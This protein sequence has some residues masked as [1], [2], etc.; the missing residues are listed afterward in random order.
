MALAQKKTYI[1]PE[2]YLEIR[3]TSDALSEYVDGEVLAMAGNSK[4][5]G[6]IVASLTRLVGNFLVDKPCDT[7]A[8]ISIKAPTSYLIP[9]LVV[10][11]G[12]GEFTADDDLLLNP[13]V[14]FE[15][16][17]DSTERYDRGHKWMKYQQIDSLRHY[18]MIS[19]SE[20]FVEVY[21]RRPDG[22]WNYDSATGIARQVNLGH[23]DLTLALA[24]IYGRIEFVD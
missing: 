16:L 6:I 19:Q 21:S 10:Y 13:L 1:S 23:L 5:H 8:G 17:S 2:Q 11:C 24:D 12:D 20:P 7:S 18:V 15:V 3:R 9:D 14:V 4:M 22:G